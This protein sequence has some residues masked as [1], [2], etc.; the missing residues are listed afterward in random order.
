MVRPPD[1]N[2]V[3]LK[4]LSGGEIMKLARR[5]FLAATAAAVVL[6][7]WSFASTRLEAGD[8]VIESVSDGT[9][10]LPPSFTMSGL[11]EAEIADLTARYGLSADMHHP[12]CNLTLLRKGERLVLFDAGSGPAFMGSAGRILDSLEAL[13]VSAEEITDL[14]ITHAHPDHIWGLLDEFDEPVFPNAALAI[15][16]EEF[17]YWTDPET[18]STIGAERESFAAGAMRRLK[19]FAEDIRLLKDGE[20]VLPGVTA[21]AT[22]GHTPGHMSYEIATSEGSVWVIGDAIGNGHIALERPSFESSSDQIPELGAKTRLQLLQDLAKSGAAII[23]YHL[24]GSGLGR[25]RAEGA[26]FRFE[27]L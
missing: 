15:G 1:R 19:P 11:S 3:W 10:T 24:P 16:A 8:L 12:P 18:A 6:P 25:I 26:G 13:G 22:P 17:S 9:L 14:V 27:E 2:D 21:R 23:G 7:R 20:E 5:H 4:T